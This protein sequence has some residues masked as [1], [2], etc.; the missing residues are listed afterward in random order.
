[1]ERMVPET[2][3]RAGEGGAEEGQRRLNRSQRSGDWQKRSAIIV[4]N[5]T[6]AERGGVRQG[7]GPGGAGAHRAASRETKNS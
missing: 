5:S 1:M 3:R 4:K 2:L 6:L 7:G